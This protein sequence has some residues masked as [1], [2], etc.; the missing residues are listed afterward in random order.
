MT[1]GSKVNYLRL[2][3]VESQKTQAE[4]L[5]WKLIAVGAVASISLGLTGSDGSAAQD[6]KQLLLCSIPLICAYTDFISIHI[7]LRIRT[8]GT[9]LKK[10]GDS[11]EDFVSGTRNQ[12]VNPFIFEIIALHGSSIIFN[13]VLISLSYVGLTKEWIE[14]SYLLGGVLG[15][16]ITILSWLLYTV[17]AKQISD[18][19]Y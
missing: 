13:L 12:G 4:F 15:L 6:G 16:F 7:M 14:K 10:S 11:Y 5:K 3:I 19:A 17:R 18:L 1:D 9:Y 2:E 8:I